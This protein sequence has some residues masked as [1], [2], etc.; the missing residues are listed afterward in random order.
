MA[1]SRIQV[2]KVEIAACPLQYRLDLEIGGSQPLPGRAEARHALLEQ[3][4]GGVELE[5][6]VDGLVEAFGPEDEA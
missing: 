5:R 3:R 4:E 1:S 2:L 6:V